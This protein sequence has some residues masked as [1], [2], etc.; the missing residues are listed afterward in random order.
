MSPDPY[1]PCPCGSGKKYKFCCKASRR[2]EPPKR[3]AP[4]FGNYAH[5]DDPF[6]SGPGRDADRGSGPLSLGGMGPAE[7]LVA[8]AQPL[9]DATDGSKEQ[10]KKAMTL[11][12]A[13]WTLSVTPD[14]AR[15]AAY[16]S[17]RGSFNMDPEAFAAFR[18]DTLEPLVRRHHEMF[19]QLRTREA[20]R[21]KSEDEDSPA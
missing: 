16:E 4:A 17:M 8:Y 10:V 6:D 21:S 3:P 18:K 19:P 12:M 15:D 1:S 5:K 20:R 11:A 14:E 7:A 9:L 2:Y 13:C